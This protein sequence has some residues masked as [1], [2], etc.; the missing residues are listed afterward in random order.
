[1]ARATTL[2]ELNSELFPRVRRCFEAG[3]LATGATLAI[4]YVGPSYSEF[5]A[6]G[7]LS[8]AY[9]RNASAIGRRFAETPSQTPRGSTD[10]ANISLAI[11]SIHPMIDIGSLP[12]V[13]HQADFAA[14]AAAA[15]ADAAV[16]DGAVAMAWTIIDVASNQAER[17]RLLARAAGPDGRSRGR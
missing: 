1:M 16:R 4:D 8:S 7:G 10:M 17:D 2:D 5:H 12:A 15:L 13:N 3:A 9:A 11:P 6:D 14:A